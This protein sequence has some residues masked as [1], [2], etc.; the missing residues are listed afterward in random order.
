VTEAAAIVAS[1]VLAALAVFQASLAAGAPLGRFAWGGAHAVLPRNLR[2]ASG[3]AV[4]FYLL[5]ALIAL[6]AAGLVALLPGDRLGDVGVWA[7]T[8]YFCLAVAMNAFSRSHSERALMAP[9]ALLL[10]VCY[11]IVAVS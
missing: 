5:F 10:A 4:A 9:V 6:E 2:V 3:V 8:A 1:V 7:V 11:L